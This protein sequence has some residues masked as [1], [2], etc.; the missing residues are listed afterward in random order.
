[1][2]R[3]C[4]TGMAVAVIAVIALG[5]CGGGGSSSPTTPTVTVPPTPAVAITARGEGNLIIHPSI[6]A[7]FFFAL[8]TP[9]RL[10]ET[11]GG[12]A[13]WNFA[14]IQLFRSGVEIERN[15]LG[16]DV[17]ERAGYKKIAAR[18]NQLYTVVFRFNDENFDDAFVT[19]GFA[20]LKDGR[21]FTITDVTGWT[22]VG[23]SFTPLSVPPGGTIR[24]PGR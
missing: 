22:D 10:T 24:L 16:A 1:M 14:R 6:D 7:S 23:L 4:L 5:S 2:A 8:E 20:D 12:T 15:E 11:A 18:G 13:D 17:I 9:I 21:Q 3:R 19:L